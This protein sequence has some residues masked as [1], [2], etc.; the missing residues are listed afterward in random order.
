MNEDNEAISFLIN[1][2]DKAM[3]ESKNNG[4]DLITKYK[5]KTLKKHL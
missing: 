2:A 5:N 4:K 3:Y 1:K